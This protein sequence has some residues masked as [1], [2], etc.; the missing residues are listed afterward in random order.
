MV[1]KKRNKMAIYTYKKRGKGQHPHLILK[2]GK[3]FSNFP[4]KKEAMKY[5]KQVK[6]LIK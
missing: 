3:Y 2:D 5:L 6:K 4:T 1:Q